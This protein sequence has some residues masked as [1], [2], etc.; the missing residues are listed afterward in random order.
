MAGC[1]DVEV[2]HISIIPRGRTAGRVRVGRSSPAHAVVLLLA[3]CI[4]DADIPEYPVAYTRTQDEEDI[5]DLI[6]RYGITR[7]QYAELK[8]CA[9]R[10]TATRQYDRFM[11]AFTSIFDYVPAASSDLLELV[12]A[13]TE[14]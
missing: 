9:L 7:S 1:L 8:I 13:T 6:V 12:V 2:E 5:R 14:D 3:G 10:L 4:E 11:T